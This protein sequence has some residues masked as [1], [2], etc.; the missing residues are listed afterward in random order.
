MVEASPESAFLETSVQS[1]GV[2]GSIGLSGLR[3]LSGAKSGTLCGLQICAR[4]SQLV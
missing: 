4:I 1:D 3:S 2:L